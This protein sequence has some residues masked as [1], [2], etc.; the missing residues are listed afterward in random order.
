MSSYVKDTH[1]HSQ[2]SLQ[3]REPATKSLWVPRE[4]LDRWTK[5][6]QSPTVHWEKKED[7]ASADLVT[8][9]SA[10]VCL[11]VN[12]KVCVTVSVSMSECL[13]HVNCPIYCQDICLKW[14]GEREGNKCVGPFTHHKSQSSQPFQFS[15]L[16]VCHSHRGLAV[17]YCM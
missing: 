3:V 17:D 8:H 11:N 16:M 9:S 10:D 4:T 13:R 1:A 6:S 5:T 12:M 7:A 15:L 14:R 2:S